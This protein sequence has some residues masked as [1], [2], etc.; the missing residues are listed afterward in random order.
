MCSYERQNM[1]TQKIRKTSSIHESDEVLGVDHCS[2]LPTISACLNANCS[3]E[4]KFLQ[5]PLLSALRYF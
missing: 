5:S 1:L 2:C 3:N 4:D